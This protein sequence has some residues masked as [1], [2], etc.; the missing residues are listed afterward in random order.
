MS[1]QTEMHKFFKINFKNKF[2][3][4]F[5]NSQNNNKNQHRL[6]TKYL[7]KDWKNVRTL[8]MLII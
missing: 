8:M 5:H 6:N 7:K 3:K 4:I 1:I 2:I